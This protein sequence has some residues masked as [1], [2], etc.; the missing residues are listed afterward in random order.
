[1]SPILI[2]DVLFRSPIAIA[3]MAGVTD[4]PFRELALSYGAPWTVTEMV[5]CS[6]L[7]TK[8]SEARGRLSLSDNGIPNVVQ[9]VGRDPYWLEEG[10]RIAA[11][12]G[13]DIIDIN[14]GCPAKRVTTGACGA[15]LMNDTE[16]AKRLVDAAVRGG[17]RPVSVKM[18]LGWKAGLHTAPSVAQALRDAGA[19]AFVVHGRTRDQFYKGIAD[20]TAVRAVVEAV[21]VPVLVN[22]DIKSAEDAQRALN[23]SGAAGLMI[24][25][26]A[27]DRPWLTASLAESL[28]REPVTPEPYV[29]LSR[30]QEQIERSVEVYGETLGVRIV[31]KHVAAALDLDGN[32]RN[33]LFL[34]ARRDCLTATDRA[35]L[36]S[37]LKACWSD[38]VA[39]PMELAS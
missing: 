8:S 16:L 37:A 7:G 14:M 22:G 5:A 24:G 6:E 20:W 4:L 26:A 11:D 15:A 38:H 3:P 19:Q 18:R 33:G 34:A 28:T 29:R 35:S 30:L 9:L 23:S 39:Y 32:E 25:R 13:A 10:A 1:L 27:V 36:L 17:Q 12:E 31:R 21:D 2:G